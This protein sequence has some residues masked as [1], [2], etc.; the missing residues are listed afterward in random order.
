MWGLK[1]KN[2]CES[3]SK[4]HRQHLHNKGSFWVKGTLRD[5]SGIRLSFPWALL[6]FHPPCSSSP[7]NCAASLFINF[8]RPSLA[9]QTL[10]SGPQNL[11]SALSTMRP[12]FYQ[13]TSSPSDRYASWSSYANKLEFELFAFTQSEIP[14]PLGLLFLLFTPLLP[15]SLIDPILPSR[16]VLHVCP[17]L[18]F[19]EMGACWIY[20]LNHFPVVQL[21]AHA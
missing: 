19:L 1:V 12:L 18:L 15:R 6:P 11:P 16:Y 20:L 2:I 7:I 8:L 3:E 17:P 5:L 10:H 4:I 13:A 9:T 14:N 21:L